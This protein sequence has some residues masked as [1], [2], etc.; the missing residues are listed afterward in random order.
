M[1]RHT[2]LLSAR[3][4]TLMGRGVAARNRDKS[5][6][7]QVHE[8]EHASQVPYFMA[9]ARRGSDNAER[10][11]LSN[12]FRSSRRNQVENNSAER[13]TPGKLTFETLGRSNHDCEILRA[14]CE[15]LC[16]SCAPAVH[17]GT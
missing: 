2:P 9:L 11:G 7:S 1:S 3:R 4:A 8:I 5:G 12:T 10:G 16:T 13:K 17:Q 14:C 6:T 15:T